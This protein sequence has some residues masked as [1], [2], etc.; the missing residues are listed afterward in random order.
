MTNLN[1]FNP[2]SRRESHSVGEITTYKVLTL[3]SWALSVLVSVWYT[4]HGQ[5]WSINYHN[6][7]AFTMNS[8]LASIYWCE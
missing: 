7:S 4:I 6:R 2:F 5:I 8:V 1:R 3:L